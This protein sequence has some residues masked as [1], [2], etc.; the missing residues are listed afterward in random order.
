MRRHTP[1]HSI[2]VVGRLV[3]PCLAAL[4]LSF[5]SSP[6]LAQCPAST[7]QFPSLGPLSTSEQSFDVTSPDNS[8]IRGDHRI[9][10]YSLHHSGYLAPT[11][12]VARDRFD[13]TGVPP[14]THMS[15]TMR[16]LI[17]GWTYTD[18]CGATGWC[19]M[20]VAYV[21]AGADTAMV[22]LLG[23]TFSG[24]A[25]FSGV[26]ELPVTFVAGTPRTLEVEMYA[27][28]CPGGAHTV[29]A[30]GRIVFDGTNGNA[31]VVSCNGFG[32]TPVPVRHRSWGE[33]KTIYR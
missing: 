1:T 15:V 23:S 27:R 20:L 16:F 4:S 25:D 24:R 5:G 13:V 26:A 22:P 2:I 31:A 17:D 21:R 10:A 3:L 19:G 11:D 32:P 8:W 30:T 18:G 29:D 7:L 6:A 9:G 14:G 12:I 33:V 28:R